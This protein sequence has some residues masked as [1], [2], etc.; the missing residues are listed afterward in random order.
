MT[1]I[2]SWQYEKPTEQSRRDFLRSTF[3]LTVEHA[4]HGMGQI[5]EARKEYQQLVEE[6][7]QRALKH[8]EIDRLV[9][10]DALSISH[11]VA[12]RRL[13]FFLNDGAKKRRPI[14]ETAYVEHFLGNP[15]KWPPPGA[16]DEDPLDRGRTLTNQYFAHVTYHPEMFG[17]TGVRLS[18]DYTKAIARR[19][20]SFLAPGNPAAGLFGFGDQALVAGLATEMVDAVSLMADH[21]GADFVRSATVEW[22]LGPGSPK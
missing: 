22:G 17:G 15:G 1:P 12:C 7:R 5:F 10:L 9:A 3:R 16:R 14:P 11:L 6:K 18:F 20:L 8:P 2:R 13:D 21:P 4:H 19:L